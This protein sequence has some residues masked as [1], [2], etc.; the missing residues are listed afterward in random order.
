MK[1]YFSFLLFTIFSPL[2]IFAEPLFVAR[3]VHPLAIT[4]DGSR[5]LALN[6]EEGR[7][8]IFATGEAPLLI[9]EIQVGLVPVSIRL[10]T[11]DEVWVVNELSDS[12][13]VVSISRGIVIDTLPTG[14]EPG[15]VA[16]ADGKAF[17]TCSRNN[18]LDVFDSVSRKK[19]GEIEL[20]GLFPRSLT[21]SP[22]GSEVYV[23]FLHTSNGTTVLPRDRAPPQSVPV[24]ANSELPAPP[25]TAQIVP[26]DHPGISYDV[27]D[28]DLAVVSTASLTVTQ[29]HG[30]LGT[31]IF[32]ICALPNGRILVPNS[33]ARNQILFEPELRARFVQS[34][35]AIL[36]DE[37]RQ[38]DLNVNPDTSF[39]VI[40]DDDSGFALAQAMIALADGEHIWIAAFGSDR[41]ARIDLSEFRVTDRI[42]LRKNDP[43]GE[44]KSS[45]VRGPR[46]LA[47]DPAVP[48]LYVLNK[49]SHTLTTLDTDNGD[50][51][52]ETS[53]SSTPD[54]EAGLK[55]GRGILFDARLSG[56][57]TVSCASCHLDLERDGM[58]WDLGNPSGQMSSVKGA[59]LSLHAP[60]LFEDREMHPMKG[61][62]VTQTLVGLSE[63]TKLHWRGDKPSIQSFNSTFPNLL[64]GSE[65]PTVQ[66]DQVANY[67]KQLRHHPNPHL[68]LDRSLPPEI[69]GGNP[70]DGIAV[71]ALFDNHCSACHLLPS[72]TSNNIDSPSNVGSNQPLKDAPLRTTYQRNYFTPIPGGVSLTGFGLGSDGSL[73]DL[74]IG[75]PYSLHILD[76]IDRPLALRQKEKRDLTA[77]ILAFDTG[78][79]P[80]VGHQLTFSTSDISNVSKLAQLA[81]LESQA[82]L[83]EFTE[84]AVVAEG[85]F[86]G[87]PRSLHYDVSISR[88][89]SDREEESPLEAVTLLGM[90]AE[91]D[92]M[93]FLGVPI[94]RILRLSTDRNL[95]GV[96][97]RSE[98][99][100]VLKIHA[101]TGLVWSG[102]QTD[103]FPEYSPDLG[104]W[105]PFTPAR[106]KNEGRFQQELPS[107]SAGSFFRL[108]RTR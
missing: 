9:R 96:P 40:I 99:V 108:R 10:R 46:G 42:D 49:L 54:L 83:G 22:D 104:P 84:I 53:L 86:Q 103:W 90:M 50:L 77:F 55:I 18:R 6:S 43:K 87:E 25:H 88:Y 79:A 60:D 27:S 62:M 51:V 39:P 70:T 34:R 82:S 24:W 2:A 35:L 7:L 3:H 66:M 58:A 95:N 57:G 92:V 100:P 91:E 16:F 69:E 65:I 19:T 14:D 1:R 37:V 67:L 31:N 36:G 17:V 61:P 106:S 72:G 102:E 8:S 64:G 78:T 56:N 105:L 68:Q 76:D 44:R 48:R 30:D 32:T 97:D 80:A 71:F 47:R 5:L 93:T 33:E 4:E 94:S 20:Q 23:S 13:S 98:E 29:Y 28:H 38:R 15:D 59:F 45:T 11:S 21:V 75:H 74:P 81:I 52:A 63:Q 107:E 41:I 101:A 73:H 85:I 12:I 89:V 26:V